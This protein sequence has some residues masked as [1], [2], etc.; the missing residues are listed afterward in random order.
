MPNAKVSE[1]KAGDVVVTDGSF[2]CMPR[3]QRK[4]VHANDDGELF[5]HCDHGRHYLCGQT[6]GDEYIGLTKSLL[7]RSITKS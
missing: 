4:R 6:E 1:I 3:D 5:I 7:R 2:T